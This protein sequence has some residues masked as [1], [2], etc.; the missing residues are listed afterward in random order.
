VRGTV[1]GVSGGG[2]CQVSE[3]FGGHEKA[4]PGLT[5]AA[6]VWSGSGLE[7]Q[8]GGD[9]ELTRAVEAVAGGGGCAEG[10][11][12]GCRVRSDTTLQG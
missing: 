7:E 9:L 11:S 8:L 1:D 4:A 5:G 10:T 6:L 12:A 2:I 3:L